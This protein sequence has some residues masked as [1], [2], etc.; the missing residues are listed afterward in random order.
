[1]VKSMYCSCEELMFGSLHPCQT[2]YILPKPQLMEI[3]QCLKDSVDF[4]AHNMNIIAHNI[5][6]F[7]CMHPHMHITKTTFKIRI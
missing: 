5:C 1:M 4:Y 6:T 3:I 7:A 2:A